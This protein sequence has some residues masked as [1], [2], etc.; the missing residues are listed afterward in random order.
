MVLGPL[1][2]VGCSHRDGVCFDQAYTVIGARDV[3]KRNNGPRTTDKRL[4]TTDY[5]L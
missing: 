1:S 4:P 5:R 3:L 2:V